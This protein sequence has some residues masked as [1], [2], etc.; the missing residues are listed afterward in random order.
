MQQTSQAEPTS[1]AFYATDESILAAL[2]PSAAAPDPAIEAAAQRLLAEGGRLTLAEAI[3]LQR[4]PDEQLGHLAALAHAV[5]TRFCGDEVELCSIISGKTGGCREDCHFCS[6]SSH[7][8]SDVA[9][10]GYIPFDQLVRAAEESAAK[11]AT[12]FCVIYAVRGPDRRLMDHVI[13]CVRLV[14][15]HT[16]LDVACSLGVLTRDQAAELAEHG[17]R[18]Y[19][20]NLETARAYFPQVCTSHRWDDRR[21]TCRLVLEAGMQLCC[22]GII[23]LGESREQRL[24]LAFELA[25]LGPHDVPMNFLNPRPG[26]LLGDRQVVDAREAIRTIALFRLIMPTA[27][28]RYAGGREVTLGELQEVGLKSGINAM[29]AG[30]YLTTLGQNH[31]SDKAMLERLEM[32]VK[33]L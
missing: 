14:H 23:G 33:A 3:A 22:G 25:E 18:R 4:L 20:H 2:E 16:N 32:P 11:G 15:E 27:I 26:T 17:V 12:E 28:M 31:E 5:R 24:E 1:N 21:D 9:P 19:N 7:S 30:N 6:Q 13:E 10:T 8:S 29:I